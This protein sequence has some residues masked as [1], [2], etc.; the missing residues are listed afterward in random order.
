MFFKSTTS[1]AE[2]A[3]MHNFKLELKAQM[4]G[5]THVCNWSYD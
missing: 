5:M 2:L 4:D 1:L 3:I